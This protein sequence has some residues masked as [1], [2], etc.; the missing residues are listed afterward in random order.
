MNKGA[1][2]NYVT[3][4]FFANFFAIEM[5]KKFGKFSDLPVRLFV[6]L[7]LQRLIISLAPE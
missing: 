2:S 5:F 7:I 3:E 4:V 6:G 1:I